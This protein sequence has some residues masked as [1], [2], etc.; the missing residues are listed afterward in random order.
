MTS[1]KVK[2]SNKG[3]YSVQHL[4]KNDEYTSPRGFRSTFYST[5]NPGEKGTGRNKLPTLLALSRLPY[6]QQHTERTPEAT[7]RSVRV[8]TRDD[9]TVTLLASMQLSAALNSGKQ[10]TVG[11]LAQLLEPVAGDRRY[12]TEQHWYITTLRTSACTHQ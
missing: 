3:I 2:S 9:C 6:A 4:K 8:T 10:A 5:T 7:V 12:S 1:I 11:G